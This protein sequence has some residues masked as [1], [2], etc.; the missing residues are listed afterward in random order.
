L[1]GI[2]Q[3]MRGEKAESPAELAKRRKSDPAS[4]GDIA[5]AG[6]PA[7]HAAENGGGPFICAKI[8]HPTPTFRRARGVGTFK[9]TSWPL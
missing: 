4:H 8:E 1:H 3:K 2:E 5:W 6:A 9:G 7:S